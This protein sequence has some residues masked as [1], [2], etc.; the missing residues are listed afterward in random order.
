MLFQRDGASKRKAKQ[1]KEVPRTSSAITAFGSTAADGISFQWSGA[2]SQCKLIRVQDY[3]TWNKADIR[4]PTVCFLGFRCA[5]HF[6]PHCERPVITF[7][8]GEST[9]G[10]FYSCKHLVGG[11]LYSWHLRSTRGTCDGLPGSAP[12]LIEK[13]SAVAARPRQSLKRRREKSQTC[14]LS[15]LLFPF[16]ARSVV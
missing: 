16:A 2:L 11:K 12:C 4:Q 10:G 6:F 1:N 3:N 15:A 8:P 14:R 9:L 13:T 7:S 5:T